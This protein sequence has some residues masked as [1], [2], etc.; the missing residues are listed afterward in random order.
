MSRQNNTFLDYYTDELQY[1]RNAGKM[2]AKSHPKVAR[3]LELSDH[4]SSDPHVERLLESFAFLTAK[5]SKEL[6][7]TYPETAAALL[8]TLYPHLM[9]PLPAMGISHFKVDP[10]RGNLTNGYN[11]PKGTKLF[12]TSTE[13]LSCQFQTVYDLNLYPI[14]VEKIDV[15]RSDSYDLNVPSQHNWFLK[16][17]L[18]GVNATIRDMNLTSLD[19]HLRGDFK[20][21]S[22]LYETIFSQSHDHLYASL[23]GQAAYKLPINSIRPMGFDV[24]EMALPAEENILHSYQML[25]EY[26]HL[27]EKF[28]FFKCQNLDELSK[29]SDLATDTLDILIEIS[30]AS[31]I[32]ELQLTPQNFVLGCTPIINLFEKTS[33]P[34]RLDGRRTKYLLTPDQ[35][36]DKVT[37]IYS[38]KKIYGTIEGIPEAV[39]C[40]PYY[41]FDHHTTLNSDTVYWVSKRVSANQRNIPGTDMYLSFVD[42]NFNPSSPPHNI[43]YAD[44][45]CTNRYLV[46][47]MPFDT[48]LQAHTALPVHEIVC[49]D[50]PNA[51]IESPTDGETL[52]KIVS[53][54][55]VNYLGL[56]SGPASVAALK[57][58]LKLYGGHNIARVEAEIQSINDIIVKETVRRVSNEAWRGFTR[59]L[60]VTL[61]MKNVKHTGY[62]TFLLATIIREYCALHV[63]MNTF[64]EV[65]LKEDLNSKEWKRWQPL[66]G[67]QI[68]L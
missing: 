32:Y 48:T 65:V 57:D 30:D 6:D 24:D 4:E 17:R 5:I 28:L 3:R 55:S 18:K 12:T 52:W 13:G 35:R 67:N 44:T 1:L 51:Q 68:R 62:S 46:E 54:L 50:K 43:L 56:S 41:G 66:P 31:Y 37:E 40:S 47:Q 49:L 60:E 33:D 15:V 14:T 45:L 11:V 58:L 22:L 23:N 34:I 19:F 38:I 36:L 63:G 10:A 9:N 21:T 59:G 27:P 2:F 7:D 26:F 16:I 64:V 20:L 29:Y 53:Q 42:L 39:P 25:Q 8:N 61:L